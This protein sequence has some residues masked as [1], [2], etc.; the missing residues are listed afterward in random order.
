M[1]RA[2]LSGVDEFAG[3]MGTCARSRDSESRAQ[4]PK[5]RRDEPAR[6]V[7]GCRP[8]GPIRRTVDNNFVSYYDWGAVIGLGLDLSLRARTD[9]K[10]T[11]DDYMRRM[12]Q[13]FG[14]VTPAV[15]GV[16][17]RPYT[18]QDLRNVLADVSGDR[19]FADDFFDRF[20]QGREVVDY[21]PLLAR[22]GLI[23]RKRNPGRPWIGDVSLDFSNGTPRIA[24]PTVEDTPRV[25]R[26]PRSRRRA[27]LVRRRGGDRPEPSGRS[28]PAPAPWRHGALV[29]SPARRRAGAHAD[30]R[31]R[32]AP[33]ARAGGTDGKAA[34]GRRACVPER[35]ARHRSSRPSA[36]R[37]ATQR[38]VLYCR[39]LDVR[40]T[41]R[42][43]G[44]APTCPSSSSKCSSLM[45][46]WWLQSHYGT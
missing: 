3:R 7:R 43:T 19:A 46:L 4:V 10:V 17:A 25:R 32:S 38:A 26:R 37:L 8:C 13:E 9:H 18:M 2:G 14:R 33:A 22:A 15:E 28:R 44:P 35:V 11:L 12:W 20:V 45:G 31:R 30:R 1:Q 40:P 27:A 16:V 21:A 24:V 5:R 34:D 42:A 23:L 39:S 6:P 41:P 29:D 36:P